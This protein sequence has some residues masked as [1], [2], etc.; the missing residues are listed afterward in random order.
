MN[1]DFLFRALIAYVAFMQN[2]EKDGELPN[3][4]TNELR[5]GKFELSVTL[6]NL[7]FKIAF[8]EAKKYWIRS[9]IYENNSYQWFFE[10]KLQ[11]RNLLETN[12]K[13]LKISR[14]SVIIDVYEKYSCVFCD[15]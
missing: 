4:T 11:K 12:E 2:K 1:L 8:F 6:Q 5:C 15:G 10:E 7:T 13:P 14:N 3:K 9:E